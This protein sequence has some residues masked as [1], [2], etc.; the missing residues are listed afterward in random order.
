MDEVSYLTENH[1]TGLQ[2]VFD[3]YPHMDE[4]SYPPS[5]FTIKVNI[6]ILCYK[7]ST[8]NDKLY[9]SLATTISPFSS[10]LSNLFHLFKA[11]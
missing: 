10:N 2:Y 11:L 5:L 6:K 4:V 3:N 7:Y 8:H 1:S 9:F